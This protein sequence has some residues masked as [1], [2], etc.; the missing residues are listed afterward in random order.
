MD[1]FKEFTQSNK[2]VSSKTV[3]QLNKLFLDSLNENMDGT[4]G[5]LGEYLFGDNSEIALQGFAAFIKNNLSKKGEMDNFER[6]SKQILEVSFWNSPNPNF[7]AL[8]NAFSIFGKD[9]LFLDHEIIF[10]DMIKQHFKVID[11]FSQFHAIKLIEQFLSDSSNNI[12]IEFGKKNEYG[13]PSTFSNL[14]ET[15]LSYFGDLE[16]FDM[17]F[18]LIR[19]VGQAMLIIFDNDK[20]LEIIDNGINSCLKPEQILLLKSVLA[21]SK[22]EF[23]QH[24]YP[25]VL[26]FVS[27]RS[28]IQE[29]LHGYTSIVQIIKHVYSLDGF[30]DSFVFWLMRD[31]DSSNNLIT[32]TL[33]TILNSMLKAPKEELTP[34]C[35]K[36]INL[37]E[38]LSNHSK[39]KAFILP[40]ILPHIP[41][42]VFDASLLYH[43]AQDQTDS[44]FA[45]KCVK[46]YSISSEA[47]KSIVSIIMEKI[48]SC[49]IY[50]CMPR[51]RPL[52]EPIFERQPEMFGF[53]L[54]R[55]ITLPEYSRIWITIEALCSIV[56]SKWN[57]EQDVIRNIVA[58]GLTSGNWDIRVSS[59]G[60]YVIS[61][62]PCNEIEMK[63][64]ID[65]FENLLFFDS[66]KYFSM[67]THSF[68]DMIDT[69][70]SSNLKYPEGM[71]NSLIVRL[72]DI[73]VL[74]MKASYIASH[75][76]YMMDLF[77]ILFEKFPGL[78][79]DDHL[80]AF[81]CLLHDNSLYSKVLR[82]IHNKM[83]NP[84]V[85]KYYREV[86]PMALRNVIETKER[87]SNVINGEDEENICEIP[88]KTEDIPSC[89]NEFINTIRQ[90]ENESNWET[91]CYICNLLVLSIKQIAQ[92]ISPDTIEMAS[93]VLFELLLKTKKLGFA[94]KGQIAFETISRFVSKE[95]LDVF[96]SK[97]SDTLLSLL[98]GFDME[99]MRRSASLPYLALSL[100]R[101]KPND[102]LV[103]ALLLLIENPSN[104]NE[105]IQSLHVIRAILTD[106]ISNS[107]AESILPRSLCACLESSL[108]FDGWELISS[109]NLCLS[110]VIKKIIKKHSQ[111]SE[112]QYLT[113]EQLFSKM[114]ELRE[115]ILKCMK[116]ENAHSIYLAL[117]VLN[118]F[119]SKFDDFEIFRSIVPHLYSK[120]IRTRRAASRAIINSLSQ[121]YLSS[122]VIQVIQAIQRKHNDYFSIPKS[123]NELHGLVILLND[124]SLKGIHIECPKLDIN[125]IPPPI[126]REYI[127]L[128]NL[129]GENI[130]TLSSLSE[131][132]Y[133]EAYY[134]SN[135]QHIEPSI[136]TQLLVSVCSQIQDKIPSNI[137]SIIEDHIFRKPE[138]PAIE[139]TCLPFLKSVSVSP[140]AILNKIVKEERTHILASYI[141]LLPKVLS[142]EEKSN[143]LTV[144]KAFVF[145]LGEDY[146][147]V[148]IAI[149][150]IL[151]LFLD[152]HEGLCIALRL[153]IDEIPLVRNRAMQSYTTYFKLPF[154]C[155]AVLIKHIKS[156]SINPNIA[157]HFALMWMKLIANKAKTDTHGE[158]LT[159]FV[160]EFLYTRTLILDNNPY[161]N[162]SFIPLT[163]LRSSYIEALV[164]SYESKLKT[165]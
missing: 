139:N 130:P 135:S 23:A 66:P 63:L 44:T 131:F 53:V 84:L 17:S 141:S 80:F 134:F 9:G 75:K 105:S 152:T 102:S 128:L 38:P 125:K 19:S 115:K 2:K 153:L 118:H 76:Q 137:Q 30:I 120:N 85:A 70:V 121:E 94:C 57:M 14:I 62:M 122:V 24:F 26:C 20:I 86:A 1:L 129:N 54:N 127:S 100:I 7:F 93:K 74:H 95:K 61:G 65:N 78:F 71:I 50:R 133:P 67:I 114:P 157:Q 29:R 32:S 165:D 113:F 68:S 155:E 3:S 108:K 142:N 8:A 36:I 159:L 33:K 27:D 35:L 156:Q 101:L 96:V 6:V 148:H 138:N 116:S 112:S 13:S 37:I 12:K 55:I 89:E 149:A 82:D 28:T 34:I 107:I 98:S 81:G 162:I 52:L 11:S 123:Y 147:P 158:P 18:S 21:R 97:W 99:N 25:Q 69:F 132:I 146:T 45:T 46:S 103:N 58:Y 48:V 161:D 117:T 104:M 110:A 145:K 124:I 64:L 60:V 16:T 59:F 73:I 150:D 140:E 77:N 5:V 42:D 4:I 22:R 111:Q 49:P 31:I 40:V 10:S 164:E 109:V 91:Q 79:K 92:D 47:C 15:A 143:I 160:D 39:V 41:P 154:L 126:L 87:I 56:K 72:I 88:T 83:K 43:L 163:K 106:K 51:L 90:L 119:W 136:S 151:P 144:I